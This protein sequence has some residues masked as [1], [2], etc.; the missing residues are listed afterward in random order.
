MRTK[1]PEHMVPTAYVLLDHLPLLPSGK[2]DR[3]ALAAIS[4]KSLRGEQEI[5]P[6]RTPLEKRL[7]SM[8][9]E[10]LR[11]EGIGVDQNFFELGGHS[12]MALQLI[13]RIRKSLEVEIPVRAVFEQPTLAQLATEVQGT[14][15]SRNNLPTRVPHWKARSIAAGAAET[16][17]L[18]QLDRLPTTDAQSILRRV[19]DG[20]H[21]C[22]PE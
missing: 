11:I 6:P 21:P 14:V 22:E 3:K 4:G 7:A 19:L 13:A 12:L 20:K 17:L 10:L 15:A 5:V 2:V 1:L 18:T 8:W 9:Q 16:D